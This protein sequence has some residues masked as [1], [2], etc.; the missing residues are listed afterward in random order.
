VLEGGNIIRIKD[1]DFEDGKSPIRDKYLIVLY[2]LE[3]ISVIAPLTTSKDYLPDKYKSERCVKDDESKIHC[4]FIP[5][6]IVIGSKGFF[7]P[8]N[9]Y[10]HIIS[11]NLKQR[12]ISSLT[13][14]YI[15][16]G[17]AELQDR[18]SDKEYS[19][20][21]YCIYKSSF[22]PKGIKRLL[23]P[24][25]EDLEKGRGMVSEEMAEYKSTNNF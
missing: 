12:D 24:V 18:L 9:T 13:G 6:E 15:N 17:L 25:I 19:D 8:K 23:E 16:T 3:N 7:F 21:L 1:F 2:R 14:K 20:L 4:Y 10:I 22:I 5:A 11:S